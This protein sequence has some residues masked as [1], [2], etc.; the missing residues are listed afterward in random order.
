MGNASGFMALEGYIS[1][2]HPESLSHLVIPQ[3][4]YRLMALDLR[5]VSHVLTS[6]VYEKPWQTRSLLGKLLGRGT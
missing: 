2:L 4:D 1:S 6:P 3:H 5:S